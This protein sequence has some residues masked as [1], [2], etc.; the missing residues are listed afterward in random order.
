MADALAYRFA[1]YLS[2][3]EYDTLPPS[4]VAKTKRCI[5]DAIGCALEAFDIDAVALTRA[6]VAALDG[7][8]SRRAVI[9][10]ASQSAHFLDAALVNCVAIHGLLHDDTLMNVSGHP[11]GPVIAAA[12]AVGEDRSAGGREILRAIVAG[13]ELMG[14][15]GGRGAL[16]FAAQ[17]RGLRANSI[18]GAFGAAAAA[19][20]LLRLDRDR[21]AQAIAATASFACGILEPLRAGTMEWRHETGV[22]ARNGIMA[23]LFAEQGLRAAPHAI[24]GAFGFMRAFPNL[25]A[26]AV[27]TSDF[28]TRFEIEAT[29]HKPYPTASDRSWNAALSLVASLVR[30][31]AVDHRDV[32][33]VRVRVFARKLDYPG[34]GYR[35]PFDTVDQA[36]FS[37]PW[38]IAAIV[39]Y[40]TLVGTHYAD[41]NEAAHARLV[42]LIAIEGAEG[43]NEFQCHVSIELAGGS[44][45]EAGSDDVSAST[46]F[47]EQDELFERVRR[48]LEGR[49]PLEELRNIANAVEHIDETGDVREVARLLRRG[50]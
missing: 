8:G 32:N 27:D 7:A 16:S 48:M 14:R 33:A 24:E 18:F 28:G 34:L 43:Y 17:R 15:L 29:F 35:G 50:G 31:H 42:P 49:V 21:Y 46:F 45:L 37:K 39:R 13:Y 9:W 22:A 10:G 11:A 25:P 6:T 26:D 1:E 19:A 40:G 23:G 12:F 44:R 20:S 2:E 5:F 38:A 30:E 41:L 36:A 3:M 4:V 47:P